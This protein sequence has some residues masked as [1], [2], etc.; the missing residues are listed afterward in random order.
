MTRKRA[1]DAAGRALELDPNNGRAYLALAALQ[2]SDGRHADAI[3]SA[4]RA[5]SLG[6]HDPTPLATLGVILA[7]SGASKEAVAIT[8]QALRLG[9]SPPPGVRLL[10]GNARD[11][12]RRRPEHQPHRRQGADLTAISP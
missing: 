3:A 4:R 8:E 5:V 2:L 9:P 6:P 1:Y 11:Q 12:R 10:A 7:F